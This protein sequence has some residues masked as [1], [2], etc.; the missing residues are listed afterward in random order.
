MERRSEGVN[1]IKGK[2]KRM[3]EEMKGQTKYCTT[4]N[5]KCGK[6]NLKKNKRE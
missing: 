2:K 1:D 6:S 3:I 4:E 5:D